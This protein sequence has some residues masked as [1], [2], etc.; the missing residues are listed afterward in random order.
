MCLIYLKVINNII[1]MY[2]NCN[3]LYYIKIVAIVVDFI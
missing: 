2:I 1:Y 3:N